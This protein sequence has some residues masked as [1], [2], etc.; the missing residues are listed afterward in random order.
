M[1][2]LTF[3]IDSKPPEKRKKLKPKKTKYKIKILNNQKFKATKRNKIKNKFENNRK[4]KHKDLEEI[5]KK[6]YEELYRCCEARVNSPEDAEDILQE[7]F[8]LLINKHESLTKKHIRNWLY[9]TMHNYTLN[10][11][12]K[13]K[14]REKILIKVKYSEINETKY[15]YTTTYSEDIIKIIKDNLSESEFKFFIEY[16]LDSTDNHKN[17]ESTEEDKKVSRAISVKRCRLKKKIY[18]ILVENGI[19]T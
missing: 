4:I 8:I 9:K 7:V 1:L 6:H 12:K 5:F 17:N 10:Y 16:I 3:E 13:K 2:L 18:K 19:I 15:F 11:T 14:N